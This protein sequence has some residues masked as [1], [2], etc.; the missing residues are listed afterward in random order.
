[1]RKV[2]KDHEKENAL[3][4]V[5]IAL[6]VAIPATSIAGDRFSDVPGSNIFHDDIGWL[7]DQGVTRGCNPPA[8]DQFC[9]EDPGTRQQMAAFMRRLANTLEA[10]ATPLLAGSEGTDSFARR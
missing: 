5:T 10:G 7:A 4:W 9:P 2:R 6:V 1:M 3:I 8:N